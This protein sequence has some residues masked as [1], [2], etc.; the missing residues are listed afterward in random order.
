MSR[1]M[2]GGSNGGRGEGGGGSN[3]REEM[4]GS[5]WAGTPLYA[6]ITHSSGS[7]FLPPLPPPVPGS[8]PGW[9]GG[10]PPYISY[11][12]AASSGRVFAPFWSE[13]E[14]TLCPFWSGIG[15]GF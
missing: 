4:A 15:Y 3:H 10:V 6:K 2:E 14:Y 5:R 7:I 8:N 12:G 1:G 13:N 9:G 11:I